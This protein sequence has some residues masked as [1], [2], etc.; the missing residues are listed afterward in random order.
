MSCDWLRAVTELIF[1][2]DEPEPADVILVPGS[3]DPEPA[4]HAAELYRAGFAPLV[5]P[6]GRFAKNTGRMTFARADVAAAWPGEWASEWAFLREVLRRG[7]VPDAAILRE[8]QA[9]FTWENAKFSRAALLRHGGLPRTAILCCK[10]WHAR[11]ALSYYQLALPETR[12]LCCP[13]A[14]P[15][16]DRDDWTTT[17]EGRERV[18]GEIERCGHQLGNEVLAALDGRLDIGPAVF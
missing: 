4:V 5:L 9:T 18:L 7:G 3:D 11:R 15:G 12:L 16:S 14:W 8:D 10:P 2:R 13:C 17:A 1:V 6:S